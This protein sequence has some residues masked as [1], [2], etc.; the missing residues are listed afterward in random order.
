[1]FIVHVAELKALEM[2]IHSSWTVLITG[3]NPIHIAALKQDEILTKILVKY[4][5]FVNIF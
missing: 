5:D 3:A 1:M 2:T 4:S